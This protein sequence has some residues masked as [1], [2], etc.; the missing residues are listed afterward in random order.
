MPVI[1]SAI[2]KARRDRTREKQNNAYRKELQNAVKKASRE[3]SVSSISRAF[4]YIDKAAK[5]HIIHKN[6]AARMKANLAK[7]LPQTVTKTPVRKKKAAPQKTTSKKT[8][9]AAKTPRSS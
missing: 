3:Q 7:L 8:T 2:K 5:K 4:S 6:R 9:K 1:K